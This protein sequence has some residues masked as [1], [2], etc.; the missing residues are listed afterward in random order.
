MKIELDWDQRQRL[1]EL[2]TDQRRE[3]QRGERCGYGQPVEAELEDIDTLL[4]KLE[5]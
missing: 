2:L 3:T 1:T 5:D 4:K